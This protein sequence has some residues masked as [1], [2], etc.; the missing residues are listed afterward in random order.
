MKKLRSLD[1]VVARWLAIAAAGGAAVAQGFAY[2]TR[3]P[4]W[5]TVAFVSVLIALA[6]IAGLWR[7]A[8]RRHE[9][10]TEVSAESEQQ[11]EVMQAL[12][13][14]LE[15]HR[16]LERELVEAKQ[17]AESAVMAKGEFL[18]TMSHEIR[19]PLN[20]IIPMLELLMNSK[21]PPD[22]HDFLR[23]AGSIVKVNASPLDSAFLT[24]SRC[25]ESSSS[26][27]FRPVVSSSS[28]F[29]SIF[30]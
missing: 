15:I 16:N 5:N 28:L 19:T 17:T 20:G 18:A 23:T 4:Y 11:Q 22:Q 8:S 13:A 29:A 2:F 30:E 21:L 27:R 9:A 3:Q 26:R 1:F 14:E 7:A 6:A 24:S 12:N 25:T 10:L